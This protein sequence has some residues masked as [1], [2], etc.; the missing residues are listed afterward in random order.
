MRAINTL[1]HWGV[2][3]GEIFSLGGL[4][5]ARIVNAFRPHI[6]FDDQD[7]HLAPAARHASAAPGQAPEPPLLVETLVD[8]LPDL[9]VS[10]EA[11]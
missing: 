1:R 10:I 5:K 7:L 3:V 8:E 11:R 2:H 4:E 6:L 9:A